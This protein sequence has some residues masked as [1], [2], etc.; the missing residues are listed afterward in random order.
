LFITATA[1]IPVAGPF[2]SIG[3]GIADSMGAF[4]GLYDTLDR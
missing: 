4:D 1:F 3:L 2:I